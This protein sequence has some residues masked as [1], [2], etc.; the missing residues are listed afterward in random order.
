MGEC[1]TN[2]VSHLKILHYATK[3][4]QTTSKMSTSMDDTKSDA[5]KPLTLLWFVDG[6]Q[7]PTFRQHVQSKDFKTLHT[8]N[9]YMLSYPINF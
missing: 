1:E 6:L 4:V 3:Y 8:I 9:V 7:P 5:F 2:E